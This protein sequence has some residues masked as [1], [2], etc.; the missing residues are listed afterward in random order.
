MQPRI[1]LLH[2]PLGVLLAASLTLTACGG[3][4]GGG[5]GVDSGA[6]PRDVPPAGKNVVE[7][8]VDPVQQ[9]LT[10]VAES[11]GNIPQ[12]GSTVEPLVG[13]LVSLLDAVDGLAGGF[14][15]FLTTQKPAELLEGG[16][17][18]G[19]AILAFSSG[20]QKALL[21]LNRTGQQIPGLD[22]VLARLE[23]AQKAIKQATRGNTEGGDI[24]TVTDAL[25]ALAQSLAGLPNKLPEQLQNRE[26]VSG[27][28]TT[29]SA[30][31]SDLG[32][33]L[34]ETGQLDGSGTGQAL[35]TLLDHLATNLTDLFPGDAAA[36]ITDQIDKFK[37]LFRK[38]L[39]VLL[40]PLFQTLRGVLAP[41]SGQDGLLAILGGSGDL[42][43]VERS[44][45]KGSLLMLGDLLA[46]LAPGSD[47]GG[48]AALQDSISR[49]GSIPLI[50]P[51]LQGLLGG[52]GG[53]D[54]PS[55]PVIGDLL[56]ALLAPAAGQ[57]GSLP[58]AGLLQ[59]K[60]TRGGLVDALTGLLTQLLGMPR[61]STG[62]FGLLSGVLG[63]VNN[64]L[65]TLLPG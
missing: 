51:L 1:S 6:G 50:G 26:R 5:G 36:P 34:D 22:I 29:L 3:S 65:D 11:T 53:A 46:S 2:F 59:S 56:G 63:A 8:P 54:Q 41:V 42:R 20:L 43:G 14:R 12:L 61:D 57:G 24:S 18:A 21:E 7:G 25:N 52:A 60:D 13:S 28:L 45:V 33:V 55:L 32:V 44:D 31:V 37:D 38:G 35:V 4:D 27:L 19:S 30:A 49:G 64:L 15:D 10:K 48:A 23:K 39:A 58:I 62:G 16:S 9:A 17:K 40:E 47:S